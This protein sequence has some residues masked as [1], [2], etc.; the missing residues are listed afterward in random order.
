VIYGWV[1][2]TFV[3][4]ILLA[5][6]MAMRPKTA[7]AERL[8]E[9]ATTAPATGSLIACALATLVLVAAAPAAT[10]VLQPND[11]GGPAIEIAAPDA[12][13]TWMRAAEAPTEWRPVFQGASGERVVRYSNGAHTVDLYIAYY[14]HQAQDREVINPVNSIA[15]EPG[16][17]RAADQTVRLD[18]DGQAMDATATRI[19][20]S[21]TRQRPRLVLRWY[22]VGG[23]M[24]GSPAEAKLLQLWGLVT[25]QPAAAAIAVATDDPGGEGVAL[26]TLR[27]FVAGLSSLDEL[28]ER[29]GGGS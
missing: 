5:I 28:L 1:F 6:G 4:V 10:A 3:T 11:E 9:P 27:G 25:G 13:A 7:A 26:E 19:L 23:R 24:V 18:V 15:P 14:P 16:W 29:T 22:W 12:A 2:L 8:P 17:Q 21:A 20:D